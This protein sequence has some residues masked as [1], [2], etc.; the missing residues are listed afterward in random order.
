MLRSIAPVS[1]VVLL[2]IFTIGSGSRVY[3]AEGAVFGGAKYHSDV[4]LGFDL[5]PDK[6]AFTATFDGLEVRI[7][8]PAS[9]PPVQTRAYSFVLPM[10]NAGAD[11]EIPFFVQGYVI[12][13][14][15]GA[16][17]L[18]F[19][20]NGQV[21]VSNFPYEADNS[22]LEQFKVKAGAAKECRITVFLLAERDSASGAS[23][24]LNVASIDTD[25]LKHQD[26]AKKPK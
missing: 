21:S 26:P 20:V 18:V 4:S 23:V 13:Q 22:F 24:Y 9:I 25:L 16:A 15:G 8:G 1:M 2:L 5:S 19:V 14:K 6:K 10:S 17:R 11:E 12:N 3:S 7:D